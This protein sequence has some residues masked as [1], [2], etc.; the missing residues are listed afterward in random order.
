MVDPG[1]RCALLS[2]ARDEPM[3]GTASR[4]TRWVAIEQPG[5][6]GED[7]LVESRLDREIGRTLQSAGRRHRFRPL[8]IRRPG[9][10]KPDGAGCVFIARTTRSGGWI[11]RIDLDRPVDVVRIDWGALESERPPGLGTAGPEMVHLVCTNGRHDPCCADQGR[12]VVRALDDAGVADVWEST[13]VGGDRFAANVV[14]LPHGIYHGRV[15]PG[16]A[17]ELVADLG[18][19]MLTL[20]RYRGR[21]CFSPLAQAAE[22]YAR[23]D[24][25]ERRIHGLRVL[26]AERRGEDALAVRFDHDGDA[27]EVVVRRERSAAETLTCG[28]APARP[29]RYLRE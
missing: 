6:W 11:E 23:H 19:G 5:S 7:A 17:V 22:V 29:W 25:G 28:G 4:V 18:S 1:A 20:D 9:W 13:H 14:S 8:L 12:P 27:F 26:G 16:D 3:A 24:L 2:R 10:R 15:E 21:S